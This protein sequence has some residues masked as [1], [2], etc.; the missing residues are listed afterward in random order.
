MQCFQKLNSRLD[1]S[2]DFYVRTTQ[3]KHLEFANYLYKRAVEAGDIYL[4]TYEGWYN[5]KEEAFVPDNE[6]E[7]AG[8]KDAAGNPLKKMKVRDDGRLHDLPA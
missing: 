1:I 8:F 3:E 2:N 5:V 6:A 4:D 7:L